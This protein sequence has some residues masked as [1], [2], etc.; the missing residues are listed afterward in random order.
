MQAVMC[1]FSSLSTRSMAPAT[2]FAHLQGGKHQQGGK[3]SG[4]N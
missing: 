1:V 3:H 2:L 4:C